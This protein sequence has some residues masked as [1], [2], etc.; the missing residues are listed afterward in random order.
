[1]ILCSNIGPFPGFLNRGYRSTISHFHK[2]EGFWRIKYVHLLEFVF[3][4]CDSTSLILMHYLSVSSW[5]QPPIPPAHLNLGCFGWPPQRCPRNQHNE[6]SPIPVGAASLWNSLPVEEWLVPSL[7]SFR[8]HQR[9]GCLHRPFMALAQINFLFVHFCF[10]CYYL[11][12]CHYLLFI[13][14]MALGFPHCCFKLMFI[15][16]FYHWILFYVYSVIL[17]PA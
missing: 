13:V 6:A 9:H 12:H 17:Q 4:K 8:T 2:P 15:D 1:M 10:C 5:E 3:W 11:F 16:E 7:L 14:S